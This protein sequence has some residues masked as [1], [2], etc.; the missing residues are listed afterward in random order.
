M[1]FS[2]SSRMYLLRHNQ[3]GEKEPDKPSQVKFVRPAQ[4]ALFANIISYPPLAQVTVLPTTKKEVSQHQ[5][6]RNR[7][8]FR[9]LLYQ[10][11]RLTIILGYF[12]SHH[13]VKQDIPGTTMGDID[14]V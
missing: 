5:S 10:V 11:S 4:M 1:I 8:A 14:V 13:R 9:N 12:Y 3:F 6:P 7:Q 2:S